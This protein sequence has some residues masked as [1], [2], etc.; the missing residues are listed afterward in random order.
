MK[1]RTTSGCPVALSLDML[2]DKW[3]L[4]ILRDIVLGGKSHFR[5]LLGSPEKISTNI[6][7]SRLDSLVKDGFLTRHDDPA[8]KSAAIYKPTQKSIDLLPMLFEFMN[9]GV[10]YTD[11]DVTLP[12]VKVVLEQPEAVKAG[13][14]A[15]YADVLA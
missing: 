3:S 15:R 11:A 2:G 8:N 13:V 1:K 9:W 10:K 5:E 7:S 12:G 6:L 4:V 14:L